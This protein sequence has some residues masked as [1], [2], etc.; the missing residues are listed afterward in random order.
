MT[1]NIDREVIQNPDIIHEEK[2]ITRTVM[3]ALELMDCPYE[4]SVDVLLTDDAGI[5]RINLEQRGIDR[6]TDVLSFP[7][8]E[9]EKPG[10]LPPIEELEDSLFDLDTGELIL[11]S[12]V[13]SMDRVRGQA[14]AYGH[15]PVR[16]LAFLTAHSMLHL[17]G[18]D[19]MEETERL[20]MET[21]QEQILQA[22]GYTRDC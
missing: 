11:G 21:L 4:A 9:Y 18:Y 10:M 20:Q 15:S 17:F 5:H 19:H 2:I 14:E 8:L 16:E 13:I 22:A 12:I 7:M 6:P 3:Q 1:V